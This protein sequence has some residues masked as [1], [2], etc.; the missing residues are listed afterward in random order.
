MFLNLG[1]A[2]SLPRMGFWAWQVGPPGGMDFDQDR[3]AAALGGLEGLP[4]ERLLLGGERGC[5]NETRRRRRWR[6][7]EENRRG[8]HS[9]PRL[10]SGLRAAIAEPTLSQ[11]HNSV[12]SR[13]CEEEGPFAGARDSSMFRPIRCGRVYRGPPRPVERGG[14]FHLRLRSEIR[15]AR[16]VLVRVSA[17]ETRSGSASAPW[18][19][20]RRSS[21]RSRR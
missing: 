18:A 20:S 14:L 6:L 3:F 11:L 12:L 4:R 7:G 2:N 15:P 5:R 19:G 17:D 21:R 8:D 1:S 10:G 9:N 13:R 16:S